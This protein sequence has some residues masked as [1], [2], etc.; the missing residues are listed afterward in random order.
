MSPQY[1]L[2]C[3]AFMSY[4]QQNAAKAHCVSFTNWAKLFSNR[5]AIMILNKGSSISHSTK[6]CEM[7]KSLAQWT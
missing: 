4:S 5:S 6:L 3:Q 2:Q 1:S 7:L